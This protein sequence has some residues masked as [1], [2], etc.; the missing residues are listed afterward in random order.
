MVS[1]HARIEFDGNRY[2]VPPRLARQP[3]TVRATRDGVRM[4]HQGEEAARHERSY[5]RGQLI[6]SVEHRLAALAL[7]KGAQTTAWNRRSTSWAPRHA[8]STSA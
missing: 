4:L 6:I 7:R 8:S 3:I 1:P 5:E 2:S